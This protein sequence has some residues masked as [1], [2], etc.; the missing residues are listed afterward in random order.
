MNIRFRRPQ[1]PV[2]RP[3]SRCGRRARGSLAA[4]ARRLVASAWMAASLCLMT[5]SAWAA[6]PQGTQHGQAGLAVA[7]YAETLLGL[8]YRPGGTTPERGF[9]CSGFVQHVFKEVARINLPRRARDMASRGRKVALAHL[10]PGDLVFYNTLGTRYSHVGVYVGEG[11]F[12]HA[13]R[14]GGAVQIVEMNSRYWTQRFSGATRPLE[15]A[16][17]PPLR[18]RSKRVV[19]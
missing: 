16:R 9:D 12:A 11:R 4:R 13:P 6:P 8:P 14:S 18:R 19:A 5:A 17:P 10:K 3:R 7:D 1:E 15:P 2:H